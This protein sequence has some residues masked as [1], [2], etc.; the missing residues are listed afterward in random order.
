M[1]V[2]RLSRS[3]AATA[4][5]GEYAAQPGDGIMSDPCH[6]SGM[7]LSVQLTDEQRYRV[8]AMSQRERVPVDVI[9]GR[10]LDAYSHPQL[11]SGRDVAERRRR[12][13][14]I[15]VKVA[16]VTIILAIGLTIAAVV[17][18][19]NQGDS[20]IGGFLGAAALACIG[21]VLAW[22]WPWVVAIVEYVACQLAFVALVLGLTRVA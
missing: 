18:G 14:S 21:G 5:F 2:A 9:V 13:E 6:D 17:V 10:A 1:G 8:E 19:G 3:C 11:A 15:G 7:S 12:S 22:R 4:A 20:V 16:T